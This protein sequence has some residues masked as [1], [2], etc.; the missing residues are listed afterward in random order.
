MIICNTHL[1]LNWK[2]INLQNVRQDRQDWLAAAKKWHHVSHKLG[3]FG[4]ISSIYR[5]L[6]YGFTRHLMEN[7]ID[8]H[9][10]HHVLFMFFF[11]VSFFFFRA[12]GCENWGMLDGITKYIKDTNTSEDDLPSTRSAQ[13]SQKSDFE[14][15]V[16]K[17]PW[18]VGSQQTSRCPGV[19]SWDKV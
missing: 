8:V 18:T 1:S 5:P 16:L 9:E 12:G 7:L 13:S 6:G 3:H 2:Y 19:W 17:D 10:L 4:K 14:G 15:K 11:F